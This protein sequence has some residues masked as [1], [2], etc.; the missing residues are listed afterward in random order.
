MNILANFFL[1]LPQLRLS[2]TEAYEAFTAYMYY[3]CKLTLKRVYTVTLR[4]INNPLGIHWCTWYL[5]RHK[6][7]FTVP[8]SLRVYSAGSQHVNMYACT[9]K[10]CTSARLW[11]NHIRWPLKVFLGLTDQK[12]NFANI[13]LFKYFLHL[14]LW[15]S[16]NKIWSTF[17]VIIILNFFYWYFQSH[18]I[19]S[20]AAW[21]HLPSYSRIK[22]WKF[23]FFIVNP[24][25]VQDTQE[26]KKGSH[27]LISWRIWK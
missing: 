17:W 9:V 12:W 3:V 19:L 27:T 15:I 23:F 21:S 2:V 8:L 26:N 1:Y 18:K 14:S 4:S 10:H 20:V 5:W 7:T 24:L 6:L 13:Q 22:D 16:L 25:H 11:K